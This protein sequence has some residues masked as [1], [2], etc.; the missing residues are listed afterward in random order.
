MQRQR[1]FTCPPNEEKGVPQL[2]STKWLLIQSFIH[3][4]ICFL[5]LC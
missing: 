4:S 2:G 1:G 5:P 3:L